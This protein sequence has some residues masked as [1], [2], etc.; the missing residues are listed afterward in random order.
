MFETYFM[1][2]FIILGSSSL[3]FKVNL[4]FEI[5]FEMDWYYLKKSLDRNSS[6]LGDID[7]YRIYF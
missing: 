1:I 5:N 4:S 7:Y 6:Y 3:I 2:Y